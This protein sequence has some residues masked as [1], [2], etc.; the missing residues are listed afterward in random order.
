MDS[1]WGAF[2]R[3]LRVGPEKADIYSASSDQT[4]GA[5][6]CYENIVVLEGRGDDV[7]VVN[8]RRSFD[9]FCQRLQHL[10]IG[11]G[12]VGVGIV[13]VIPETDCRYIH[14]AGTGECDFV[15]KTILF[16]EQRKNVLLKS[17]GVIG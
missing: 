3:V 1:S 7:E 13:L 4:A 10:W 2:R 14:S 17:L 9:E 6:H 5:L 12:V 11:I 15:L 16:A 8:L